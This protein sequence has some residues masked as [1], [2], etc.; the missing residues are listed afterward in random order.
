[1]WMDLCIHIFMC[2][3]MY[4]YM[5][6]YICIDGYV[7]TFSFGWMNLCMCNVYIPFPK[8]VE[9]QARWSIFSST[10]SSFATTPISSLVYM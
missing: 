3:C 1:M 9:Y 2:L 6:I 5:Y 7:V 10:K 4:V 8:L